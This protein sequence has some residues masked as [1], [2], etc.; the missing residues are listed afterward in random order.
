MKMHLET[1]TTP[2]LWF[3]VGSGFLAVSYPA[4][5]GGNAHT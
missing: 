4:V 5:E 1:L 3:V 2:R